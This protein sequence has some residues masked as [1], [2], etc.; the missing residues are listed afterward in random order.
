MR[1]INIGQSGLCGGV[2]LVVALSGCNSFDSK[3]TDTSG[4]HLVIPVDDRV[5]VKSDLAPPAISGGTLT[6]TAD[7]TTAIVSDP[8]RD[9][10]SIVD[11][12]KLTLSRTVALQPG[13]EPGR[14]VED[15]SRLIHVALRRSG[16]VVTIDPATG[17]VVDRRAVCKAPRGIAYDAADA[18]LVRTATDNGL[19]RNVRVSYQTTSSALFGG[20]TGRS[21]LPLSGASRAR[22]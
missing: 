20:F 3:P 19:T 18:M 13:D 9:Q 4:P 6:I 7:G 12:G 10:V 5:A 22:P 1:S 8:A 11:L 17:T 16:A 14:S 2:A 21:S 15:G